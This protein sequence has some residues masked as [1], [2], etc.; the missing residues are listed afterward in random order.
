MA[1]IAGI[2]FFTVGVLAWRGMLTYY[3]FFFNYLETRRVLVEGRNITQ[4]A[5]PAR[6]KN[7]STRARASCLWD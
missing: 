4:R 3:V 1:I 7:P 6:S 2:D 5:N